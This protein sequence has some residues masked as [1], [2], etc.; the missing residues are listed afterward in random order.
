MARESESVGYATV[1]A[2]GAAVLS[3][4]TA[5]YVWRNPHQLTFLDGELPLLWA[6]AAVISLIG[7]LLAIYGVARSPGRRRLPAFALAAN[8]AITLFLI[9]CP[10]VLF[11]RGVLNMKGRGWH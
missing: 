10:V 3:S 2:W 1:F 8:V 9:L 6:G 4:A 7:V 11:I 5:G